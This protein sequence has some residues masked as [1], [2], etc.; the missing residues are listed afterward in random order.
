MTPRQARLGA[1]V[2]T[3]AVIVSV[4]LALAGLTWRLQGEPG[5]GP[6]AA[7]V[8]PG[9][10]PAGDIRPLIALAPFGNPVAVADAGTGNGAVI[11]KGIFLAQ[12]VESSVVL[13]AGADGK[14]ASYGIGSAI[15]GGVIETVEAE[16]ITLR[17][18][19]GV[20][21]I[22]FNPV[23]AAGTATSITGSAPAAPGRLNPPAPQPVIGAEA[24]RAL[25]PNSVQGISP[26]PPPSNAAPPVSL[27][28]AAASGMRVGS[29]LPPALAAAGI[30]SGD[31]IQQVNGRAVDS[32]SNERDLMAS[33]VAAGSARVEL[34]RDGRRMSLTI[35]VR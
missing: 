18:P 30:R 19:S 7:P 4:A 13:I 10:G 31:V 27:A 3:G 33:A 32:A 12:P 6:S 8:A 34:L 2:F 29:S 9:R 21:V 22:G 11:L 24:V 17:M 1:D 20:Q 35:P 14:V 23:A 28:P 26:P 16:Q 5:I 25:I 15:G